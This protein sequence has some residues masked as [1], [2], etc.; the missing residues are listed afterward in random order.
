VPVS[1]FIGLSTVGQPLQFLTAGL[2]Q[3]GLQQAEIIVPVLIL[4]HIVHLEGG[5]L[6]QGKVGLMQLLALLGL[7]RHEL[8]KFM[9]IRWH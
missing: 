4:G 3:L 6:D 8:L 2:V 5:L 9:P 1:G 7:E